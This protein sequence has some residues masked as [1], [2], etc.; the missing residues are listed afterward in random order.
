[1]YR[2]TPPANIKLLW[3]PAPDLP[4][5]GVNKYGDCECFVVCTRRIEVGDELLWNYPFAHH[6][7]PIPISH[8]KKLQQENKINLIAK[9]ASVAKAIAVP[10]PHPIA[11]T[12][13]VA[14]AIAVPSPRPIAKAASVAK[15]IA[16]P[17]PHP[18]A[19]AASVAKAIAVPSPRPIA[20]AASVAKAIA[21]PS[22]RPI[23]KTASVLKAIAVPPGKKRALD[24]TKPVVKSVTS[25]RQPRMDPEL[26]PDCV[27]PGSKCKLGKC[28]FFGGREMN[29]SRKR[30]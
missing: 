9:A 23:A 19:K 13:S 22:P 12:A 25:D 1:L 7:S 5:D 10:S 30:K 28:W 17:S 20:K 24:C 3:L 21:V 29:A 11:K 16:V 8:P 18:I 4:R 15:A 2:H 26:D 14:K 27:C 6:L